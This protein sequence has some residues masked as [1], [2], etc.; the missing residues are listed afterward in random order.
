LA[1]AALACLGFRFVLPILLRISLSLG[2]Q[3]RG[4]KAT[5]VPAPSAGQSS[6]HQLHWLHLLQPSVRNNAMIASAPPSSRMH[7][8]EHAC[9]SVALAKRGDVIFQPD[10]AAMAPPS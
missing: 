4:K 2:D 10:A 8:T 9:C 3:L 1:G 5:A 6:L 7:A